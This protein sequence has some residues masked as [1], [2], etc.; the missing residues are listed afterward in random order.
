MP[1]CEY[2]RIREGNIRF[3]EWPMSPNYSHTFPHPRPI[4]VNINVL[5][6]CSFWDLVELQREKSVIFVL[7]MKSFQGEA[8]DVSAAWFGAGKKGG[9]GSCGKYTDRFLSISSE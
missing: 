6:W 5:F 4:T 1:M 8:P 2:E 7:H 3:Q 9:K